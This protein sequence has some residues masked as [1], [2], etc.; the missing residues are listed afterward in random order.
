MTYDSRVDTLQHSQ[1]VGELLAQVVK[2]LLDRS[3]CHDRSKTLPPEVSIFD[4][5]TPK[6]KT[7]T[8]GS[9]EY[10]ACLGAMG[11]GLRHHYAHNRHHPERFAN[12][13]AGMTLVDVVEMLTDWKAATERGKDGDLGKSLEI[14]RERFGLEPQ[15][16]AILENTAA[17][18]GWL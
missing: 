9:S 13:V 3:T 6:L 14:Q 11:E 7:L 12:G 2:D 8:Y 4:E 17:H 1:R 15:L 10:K 5:Y 16:A 18:F